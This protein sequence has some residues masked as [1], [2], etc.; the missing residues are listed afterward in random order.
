M[1]FWTCRRLLTL[2]NQQD[3]RVE[4]DLVRLGIR[5]SSSHGGVVLPFLFCQLEIVMECRTS[6]CMWRAHLS[7]AALTMVV[8]C[9][10]FTFD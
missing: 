7:E 1:K 9:G 4:G 3:K 5:G 2:G 6:R 8:A 10:T